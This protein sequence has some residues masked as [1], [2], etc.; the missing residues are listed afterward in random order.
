MLSPHDYL[1]LDINRIEHINLE[2]LQETCLKADWK[3]RIH[4]NYD[5]LHIHGLPSSEKTFRE[6]SQKADVRSRIIYTNSFSFREKTKEVKWHECKFEGFSN[7]F[8]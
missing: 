3:I 1:Y 2:R 6:L 4:G 8:Q 7:E 5:Y